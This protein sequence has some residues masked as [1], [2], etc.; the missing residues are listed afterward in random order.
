MNPQ[1]ID[2]PPVVN[3]ETN[4]SPEYSPTSPGGSY[5]DPS[6]QSY[7]AQLELKQKQITEY[8]TLVAR[9]QRQKDQLQDAMQ[10]TYTAYPNMNSDV[11]RK[12]HIIDANNTRQGEL[13]VKIR[14]ANDTLLDLQT[15]IDGLLDAVFGNH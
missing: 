11:N 3:L 10:Q 14:H 9:L 2:L 8:R 13:D 5:P 4:Q 15:Q 7:Y 6:F 1:Q 12:V